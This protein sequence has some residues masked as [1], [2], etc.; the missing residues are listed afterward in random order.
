MSSVSI[1]QT[2]EGVYDMKNV[3]IKAPKSSD[4]VMKVNS[5]TYQHFYAF[6]FECSH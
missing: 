2:V 3:I 5:I 4:I 6:A 1:Q